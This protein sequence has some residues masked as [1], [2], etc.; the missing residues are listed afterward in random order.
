MVPESRESAVPCGGARHL[1]GAVPGRPGRAETNTN[2]VLAVL[3]D[4]VPLSS[5]PEAHAGRQ[6]SDRPGIRGRRETQEPGQGSGPRA[7]VCRVAGDHV[8]VR[9]GDSHTYPRAPAPHADSRGSNDNPQETVRVGGY[10]ANVP[11]DETGP[12]TAVA[13]HPEDQRGGGW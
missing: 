7:E 5:A 9:G 1:P 3:K 10:A 2:G 11:E 12:P 13:A 4:G 6:V 8:G